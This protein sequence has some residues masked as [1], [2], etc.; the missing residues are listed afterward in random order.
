MVNPP[1][2]SRLVYYIAITGA[3]QWKTFKQRSS[4]I[5]YRDIVPTHGTLRPA[6]AIFAKAEA[7]KKGV[8]R[9]SLDAF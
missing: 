8:Q 4:D 6:E 3:V 9:I 5:P 1:L 7:D 2:F